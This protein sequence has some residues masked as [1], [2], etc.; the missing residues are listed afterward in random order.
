MVLR[1]WPVVGLV[2]WTSRSKVQRY[3]YV[4]EFA[5]AHS[6]LRGIHLTK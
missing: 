6:N 2:G 3:R 1:D 5:G 4:L